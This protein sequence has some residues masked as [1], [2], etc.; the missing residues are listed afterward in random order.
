MGFLMG[1]FGIITTVIIAL[2]SSFN[3]NISKTDNKAQKAIDVTADLSSKVNLLDYKMD[4]L[5]KDRGIKFESKVSLATTS[6][7][8]K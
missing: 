7:I 3:S 8:A 5:L 1:G 6:L 4:L 2:T